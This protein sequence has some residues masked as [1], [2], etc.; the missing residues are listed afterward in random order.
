MRQDIT[1]YPWLAWSCCVDQVGIEFTEICLCL[2][3]VEIKVVSYH[4]LLR[5]NF[6][7]ILTS[8]QTLFQV[9]SSMLQMG[10]LIGSSYEVKTYILFSLAKIWLLDWRHHLTPRPEPLLMCLMV[11]I[12]FFW[13]SVSWDLKNHGILWPLSDIL[14]LS[15]CDLT[16]SAHKW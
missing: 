15:G 3:S 2:P 4:S 12:H 8:K 16:E 1:V 5:W 10:Q 11:G 7:L 9:L 6:H 13:I 14:K